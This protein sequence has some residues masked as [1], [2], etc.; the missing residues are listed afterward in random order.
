M[1][2]A[3]ADTLCE[4]ARD[5]PH[6]VLMTADLG[7]MVLERFSESYPDRFINVGVAE[8]NM[9]GLA[10]GL[11]S[12]G[13][14][15]YVYSIATFASMRGYEQIRNGPVLHNLPVRIVGVGGGFEYG[16]AGIT[17]HALEDLG[18]ARVQPGLTVVAPADHAQAAA[19]IRETRDVPGPVYFRIG[20]RDDY[21]LPG[22]DGRFRLGRTETVR[23]GCDLLIIT[24]G[25]IS[26]EA[27]A[28]AEKLAEDG[29][30]ACVTVV[31]SLRP[32]PAEDLAAQL[33]EFDLAL[34]VEEHYVDCGLGSL[35]AEV[36]AEQGSGCRV[37][38]CGVGRMTAA[39]DGEAC[40]RERN[41]LSGEGLYQTAVT[42]LGKQSL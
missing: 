11:A 3:F 9:I 36:S 7:F 5:D 15:P 17:H 25:A 8:A 28:A 33:R 18:I 23:E 26:S 41:G 14:V 4:I 27:M 42:A 39:C 37:V 38:R 34:T 40:L 2:R 22:L 32:A 30:E 12:C 29:I 20:K 21:V 1:R 10:T 6:I 24:L 16:H 31:S 19:A 13:Y 35:V